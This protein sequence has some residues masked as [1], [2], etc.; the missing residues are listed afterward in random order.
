MLNYIKY[1]TVIFI[2]IFSNNI[3]AK[4][5]P[6]SKKLWNIELNNKEKKV[7]KNIFKKIEQKK[8]K[9]ALDSSKK[10]HNSDFHEAFEGII[11]RNKI[12]EL[13]IDKINSITKKYPFF[14]QRVINNIKEKYIIDNNLPYEEIKQKYLTYHSSK[15]KNFLIYMIEKKSK[16]YQTNDYNLDFI[17]TDIKNRVKH[18]WLD[19]SFSEQE[20][21]DFLGKYGNFLEKSDHLVKIKKLFWQ[22]KNSFLKSKKLFDLIS[23][24]EEKLF[25]AIIKI[26]KNPKSL[27]KILLSIPRK[28]RSEEVLYYHRVQW[29]KKNNKKDQAVKLL[30]KAP[31]DSSEPEKWWSLRKLYGRE[32]LKDKRKLSYKKSYKIISN[33]GLKPGGDKYADAEWT[34]GWIALRFLNNPEVAYDHFSNLYKNVN[35]PISISRAAYWLAEATDGDEKK[36]IWYQVA[37]RY[38][39]YFYSQIAYSKYKKLKN[40]QTNS[41]VFL[42]PDPIFNEENIK[43][44]KDNTALKISILFAINNQTENAEFILKEL[45][46]QINNKGDIALIIEL[47]AQI[48]NSKLSYDIFKYLSEKNIFFITKQ[49][50]IIKHVEGK[51]KSLIHSLIKQESGFSQSAISSVGAV[52]FMQLMPYTAKKVAERMKIKYDPKKLKRSVQ[53]NIKLGSFYINSLLEKF[54]SSKIMAIASY[55]AG[56]SSV[57]RWVKEF[58]DPRKSQDI[59][60]VVDWIELIT[61]H[62]TRNYVQRIMENLIIY[63]YLLNKD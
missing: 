12:S 8:Y 7:I 61:Y 27:R 11:Y 29:L 47:L 48:D 36:S 10:F 34:A 3:F 51:N 50:K 2:I 40:I 13:N 18:I 38:P 57:N 1:L 30:L 20:I 44:L 22:G 6:I 14:N 33:H 59:D 56:P 55:N 49:F 52:G 4:D 19:Y 26:N 21:V 53:Y 58:Y 43:N 62:E 28:Y 39:A 41:D 42:P 25:S 45:I 17:K 63:E 5:I 60:K 54:N 9:K 37:M 46:S 35:Y 24:D 23:D 15:N 32:L 16:F 31:I